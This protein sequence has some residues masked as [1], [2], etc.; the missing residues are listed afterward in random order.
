MKFKSNREDGKGHRT[1]LSSTEPSKS[2]SI[3]VPESTHVKLT[4]LGTDKVR[5]KLTRIS[6]GT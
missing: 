5:K 3:K 6:K 1:P 2:Y 4:A